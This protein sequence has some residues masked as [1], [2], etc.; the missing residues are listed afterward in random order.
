[1]LKCNEKIM[2]RGDD[3]KRL[4]HADADYTR[5]TDASDFAIGIDGRYGREK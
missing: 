3:G 2:A 4:A 5:I 1:M